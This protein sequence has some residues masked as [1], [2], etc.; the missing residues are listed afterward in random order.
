MSSTTFRDAENREWTVVVDGY[1]LSRAREYGVHIAHLCAGGAIDPAALL[2][3]CYC[4][5]QHNSRMK[6]A[7]ISREDFLRAL[8]GR[9]LSDAL[10]AT[11][12]ALAECMTI[13][14]AEAKTETRPTGSGE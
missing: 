1:V 10:Q 4:G 12:Q 14:T 6:V 13:E 7:P 2:D 11:A 5:V 3:L 8:R 9:A